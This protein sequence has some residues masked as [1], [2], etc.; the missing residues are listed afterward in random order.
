MISNKLFNT[1]ANRGMALEDD[2]NITNKYY[3]DNDIAVIHKKPTPIRVTK[4]SYPSRKSTVIKEAY[5]DKPSTTDYNGI[6]KGMY[7]DFD[8]KEVKA[9]KSFPISNIH[10]HQIEHLKKIKN[11]GGISFIIVKFYFNNTTY[12][13]ETEK[14]L[15]FIENEER[16]S[17]PIEY[18]EKYGHK[19]KE[20]YN[21]RIDYLKVINE[22]YFN[23]EVAYEK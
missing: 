5:Y 12:L 14:L 23:K 15:N 9:N 1:F 13:L 7:V 8:A 4:V 17:I 19:V 3:L 18:F 21:P 22:L 20:S 10:R 6:Y 11:H 16:K 2:I